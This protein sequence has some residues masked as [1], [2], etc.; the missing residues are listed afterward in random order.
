MPI[1]KPVLVGTDMCCL[2]RDA[3][4]ERLSSFR[5]RTRRLRAKPV[6]LLG[7]P[8]AFHPRYACQIPGTTNTIP[9]PEPR[10]P[11]YSPGFQPYSNGNSNRGLMLC[12][13]CC[14]FVSRQRFPSELPRWITVRSKVRTVEFTQGC[15][16]FSALS[17]TKVS[18]TW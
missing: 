2:L 10:Y 12:G 8:L 13:R 17:Y 3:E 1:I 15:C 9:V 7:N 14:T 11:R 4:E 16:R 5:A 18:Y 6:P